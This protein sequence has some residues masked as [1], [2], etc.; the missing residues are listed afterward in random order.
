MR[1]IPEIKHHIDTCEK[2]M[3]KHQ[4]SPDEVELG[5][6]MLAELD[7]ELR[8]AIT[9][10]IPADELEALCLAWREGKV[11]VKPCK[12]GT[13]FYRIFDGEITKHI[14]SELIYFETARKWLVEGTPFTRFW[15]E[16]AFCK[17]VF[18]SPKAAEA[19]A[20]EFAP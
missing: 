19:A 11:V 9:H 16:D 15:W 17:T 1:P 10:G 4:D 2:Y 3:K 18:F 14:V 20:K 12:K 13:E 7:R 8:Q 6:K 5:E